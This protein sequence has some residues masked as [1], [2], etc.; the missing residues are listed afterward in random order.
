[1][2]LIGIVLIAFGLFA[3]VAGGIGYTDRDTIIDLGPIEAQTEE[4][5]S[6]PL[7]PIVGIASI[8]AGVAFVVVGAKNR[9]RA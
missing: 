2:K 4:R 9:T 8:A 6:L 3:L 7:S 1:V 5:K